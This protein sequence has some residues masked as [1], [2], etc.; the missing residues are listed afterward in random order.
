MRRLLKY[1]LRVLLVIVV[2]FVALLFISRDF[3]I[4]TLGR[5][6]DWVITSRRCQTTHPVSREQAQKFFRSGYLPTSAHD[7]QYAGA[8]YMASPAFETFFRFEAPVQD[9]LEHAKT[10]YPDMTLQAIDRVF[11]P[12]STMGLKVDWFDTAKIKHGLIGTHKG[13]CATI[14]IDTERGVFYF[15]NTD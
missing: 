12:E 6:F 8:Y 11:Q 3:R 10:E 7:V 4:M 9:C 14:W 13:S 1:A 2:L 5:L 15:H